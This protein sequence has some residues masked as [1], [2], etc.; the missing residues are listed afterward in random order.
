MADYLNILQGQIEEG[1]RS[2]H[3]A[4]SEASTR[5]ILQKKKLVPLNEPSQEENE[6]E[7]E[8]QV[9]TETI[10][11]STNQNQHKKAIYADASTEPETETDDIQETENASKDSN[12]PLTGGALWDA[13]K[14]YQDIRASMTKPL[15]Q[16]PK[17]EEAPCL[18]DL[19]MQPPKPPLKPTLFTYFDKLMQMGEV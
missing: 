13:P 8:T 5:P 3:A 14:E 15:H 4:T 12:Q 2:S 10:S 9:M 6:V 16:E 18:F 1:R 7:T 19:V 17:Q 11:T